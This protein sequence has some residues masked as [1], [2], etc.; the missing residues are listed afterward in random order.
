ML[1]LLLDNAVVDI[2]KKYI[3]I[4]KKYTSLLHV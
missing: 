1:F 4:Y 2:Y 3:V